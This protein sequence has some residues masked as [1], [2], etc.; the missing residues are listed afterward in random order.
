MLTYLSLYLVHFCK[1]LYWWG[2]KLQPHAALLLKK[3]LDCVITA[4]ILQ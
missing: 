2:Q 4:Y 1:V 3:V